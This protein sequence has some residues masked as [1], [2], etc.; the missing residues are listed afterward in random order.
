MIQKNL[1]YLFLGLSA[2]LLI[3]MLKSS[4]DAGIS[5]DE[6]LHYDQSK[7][8]YNYFATLGKDSSAVNTPNTHLKYYGQ[9]FDNAT[10][11][12]IKWFNIKEVFLFRHIACAL[13]GWLTV[14]ITALF[15]L[16][17]SGYGSAI[18]VILLFAASPTFLGHAQNNL[19]DIPFALCYIAA[20]YFMSRFL[21][22]RIRRKEVILLIAS[23]AFS[24]SIRSGGLILICYLFL[25]LAVSYF[26][27]LQQ[28]KQIDYRAFKE[29]F[30]YAIGIS[31]L[32]LLF[33]IILWPYAL[34]NP[35]H[36][37]WESYKVMTQFPTTVMQIFE[38]KSIWSDLMPWYY[39]PKYMIITI[40][41]IVVTGIM[42]FIIL[43]R[44]IVDKSN[45][46]T[47]GFILFS[48]LFPIVFVIYEHS[49]LYGS[50]R[51]FTFVYPSL[52]LLASIGLLN[53]YARIKH[54]F[55]KIVF[56][57]VFIGLSWHPIQYMVKNHPYLYLYYNPIVG[58]LHGAY[59]NYETDYYYHSMREGSTWLNEY[60]QKNKEVGP[61]KIASNFSVSWYFRDQ[62]LISTY[63]CQYDARS[64]YDW[65]YMV[66]A[67]SYVSAN[68]LQ[69]KVWPPKE[70]IHRIYA[71]G[72]PIC[73]VLK[74]ATKLDFYGSELLKK[75]NFIESAKIF[76]DALKINAQD[77]LIF[78]N[79]AN[80]LAGQGKIDSAKIALQSAL[81]INPR[82]E[83][84]L[85]Y[86]GNIAIEQNRPEEAERYYKA[87]LSFNPKYSEA[88]VS[89]A[90]I[91]MR[92]NLAEARSL[93]KDCLILDPRYIPAV[94]ALA[95]TYRK[96]N[97]EVAKKYDELANSY[98]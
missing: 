51:H 55:L 83:P 76:A 35:L 65:D 1:K 84:T 41:L 62:P 66:V 98:K 43:V 3:F 13:A 81:A 72:I 73:T 40:P 30:I 20:L 58:G 88:Y 49:N 59:G 79:F 25:F 29:R 70:A 74:R 93:L 42:G 46:L 54:F 68:L 31:L 95:E 61:L 53:A 85:M 87:L 28:N 16:W 37:I 69:T 19:K 34:H 78:Y 44:K 24:I 18:L 12:L 26:Y 89:L 15:A 47:Y 36:N 57:L 67:N 32:S 56:T 33:S 27:D 7:A 90:N 48:I 9:S 92:T 2:L 4:A 64:Q 38:G 96:S 10:T 52:I 60:L 21:L 63:Y 75:G 50:W 45:L 39:L 23:I 17:L 82:Y 94:R 8:V 77:E 71:D 80:A 5:G 97:P 22:H 86:L 14:F 91:L 6:Y 11:I